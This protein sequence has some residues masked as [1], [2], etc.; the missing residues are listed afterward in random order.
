MPP[1][2]VFTQIGPQDPHYLQ[3]KTSLLMESR[4]Q[5]IEQSQ[6]SQIKEPSY[7]NAR[8]TPVSLQVR[9]DKESSAK[10]SKKSKIEVKTSIQP[11]FIEFLHSFTPSG[12]DSQSKQAQ[13]QK[14][15]IDTQLSLKAKRKS[16][17]QQTQSIL[18]SSGARE[19]PKE[20]LIPVEKSPLA[21]T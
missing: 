17:P 13:P 11:S 4:L 2:L 6:A 8:V 16:L 18:P 7:N 3:V 12:E 19:S 9:E 1:R 14:P 5:T 15:T 20:V 21:M 10:K